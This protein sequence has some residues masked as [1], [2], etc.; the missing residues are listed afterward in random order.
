MPA[1]GTSPTCAIIIPTYGRSGL[2]R[3]CFAALREDLGTR[4]DIEIIV[5]DDGSTDDTPE[6]IEALGPAVRSVVHG[7][8]RGF[9]AACNSGADA[10]EAPLL[11]FYNNDL[12]PHEGWLTNLLS[13]ADEHPGAGIFGCRLL[14]PDG[15]IQHAG[16]VL[17]SDG[18][19]RHVYAGFAADHPVVNRSG[20]AGI[21]TGACM[22][23]RRTAFSQLGGFD[24]GYIN[25]YEDVDLCLRAGDLGFEVRYVAE[26][27][28]THLVSATRIDR[29]D[30]FAASEQRFLD[31][32][33]HLPPN[34][35]ERYLSDGMLRITYGP[36]Y[37]SS[38]WIDPNLANP[39]IGDQ[40]ERVAQLTDRLHKAQRQIVVLRASQ[41]DPWA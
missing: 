26:S 32:W 22:A 25:G 31:R 17:C 3:T 6:V 15:R 18:Y 34:D 30:E 27:T 9:A 23:V 11:V 13:A 14:F 8:N 19:P 28:L 24:D 36:T 4:T 21:V 10:T 37:P 40:D 35:V 38:W 29:R 1:P 7:D 12:K 2:L 41:A 5:V 16:V 39:T 20:P 33:G